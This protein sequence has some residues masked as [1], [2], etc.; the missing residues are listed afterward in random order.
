M[1]VLPRFVVGTCFHE[2]QGPSQDCPD[3][4]GI[5]LEDP[6]IRSEGLIMVVEMG[7]HEP[8]EGSQGVLVTVGEDV[9]YGI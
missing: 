5:A 8:V 6:V 2:Q 7:L 4:Q 9:F 1:E 3:I